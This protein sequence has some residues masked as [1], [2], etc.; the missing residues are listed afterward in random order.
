MPTWPKWISEE[1]RRLAP[2]R[3]SVDEIVAVYLNNTPTSLNGSLRILKLEQ[4]A[5]TIRCP[6]RR[7]KW[8]PVTAS[9]IRAAMSLVPTAF[10][11]AIFTRDWFNPVWNGSRYLVNERA[12]QAVVV[13]S[14]IGVA[15][16][17]FQVTSDIV[18][19]SRDNVED[20]RSIEKQIAIFF[21]RSWRAEQERAARNSPE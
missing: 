8:L 7:P 1:S 15:L 20:E 9:G 5:N 4:E 6:T 18:R 11:A 10:I 21:L 3:P 19:W 14:L 2:R 16:V 13:V 17:V 12:I